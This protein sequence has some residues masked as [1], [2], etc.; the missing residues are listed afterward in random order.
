M[1]KKTMVFIGFLVVFSLAACASKGG[2]GRK[3]AGF[4]AGHE[5]AYLG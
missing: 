4:P 3:P 1:L 5:K 2:A